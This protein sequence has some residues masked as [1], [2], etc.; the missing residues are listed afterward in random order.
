[1][2]S[3][4]KGRRQERTDG[5]VWRERAGDAAGVASRTWARRRAQIAERDRDFRV[6]AAKRPPREIGIVEMGE[7][8]WLITNQR[9]LLRLELERQ[10]SLCTIRRGLMRPSPPRFLGKFAKAHTVCKKLLDVVPEVQ[11]ETIL[12]VGATGDFIVL[13]LLLMGEGERAVVQVPPIAG[14]DPARMKAAVV[15]RREAIR[16]ELQDH[17]GRLEV[18][19]EAI[20]GAD[21]PS[22]LSIT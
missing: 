19:V 13:Q 11:A 3:G 18:D 9:Q 17:L 4:F 6:S 15:H 1:M 7:P 22:A 12:E 21:A 20:A 14:R 10:G 8:R 2:G 16:F 5:L